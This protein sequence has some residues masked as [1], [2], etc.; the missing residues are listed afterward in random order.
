MRAAP[1]F[2]GELVMNLACNDGLADHTKAPPTD[3]VSVQVDEG[4]EVSEPAGV[5]AA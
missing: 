5:K 3:N 2:R 1:R 4:Y